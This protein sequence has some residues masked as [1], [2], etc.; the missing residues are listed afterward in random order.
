MV[1]PATAFAQVDFD[2]EEDEEPENEVNSLHDQ[3]ERVVTPV[4]WVWAD[5]WTRSLG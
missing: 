1:A 4:P 5:V 2:Q 3:V